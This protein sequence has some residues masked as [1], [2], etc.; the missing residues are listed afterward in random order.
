MKICPS[1]LINVGNPRSQ[2]KGLFRCGHGRERATNPMWMFKGQPQECHGVL[3][4]TVVQILKDRLWSPLISMW[5]LICLFLLFVCARNW[6]IGV[7]SAE[8]FPSP[9]VQGR[10]VP[11]YCFLGWATKSAC[12]CGRISLRLT[13]DCEQPGSRKFWQSVCV[14]HGLNCC[15]IPLQLGWFLL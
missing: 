6:G 11:P 10:A 13:R 4:L 2:T 1:V 9:K 5:F 12:Q 8:M 14:K 3:F 15:C 7:T